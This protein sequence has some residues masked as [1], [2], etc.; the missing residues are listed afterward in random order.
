MLRIVRGIKRHV[1]DSPLTKR[2]RDG[3]ENCA[4]SNRPR[5]RC[6]PATTPVVPVSAPREKNDFRPEK[7]YL[8]YSRV[9]RSS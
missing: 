6:D 7:W 3:E 9:T 4:I 1:Q 2:S 5:E 8:S